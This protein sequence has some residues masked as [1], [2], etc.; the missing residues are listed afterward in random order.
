MANRFY[1]LKLKGDR[2]HPIILDAYRWRQICSDNKVKEEILICSPDE[3]FEKGVKEKTPT[4]AQVK[5]DK[6]YPP[7]MRTVE[8]DE[9][10]TE[11]VHH[12]E[13][14]EEH[15]DIDQWVNLGWGNDG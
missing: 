13:K 4:Q 1:T 10:V 14:I 12:M 2:K 8:W 5:A 6:D 3:I 7:Y 9:E 15:I 11:T